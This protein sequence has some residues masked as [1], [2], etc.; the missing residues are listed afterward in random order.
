MRPPVDD[1][2]EPTDG[3]RARRKVLLAAVP[4]ILVFGITDI[5]TIGHFS[6]AVAL[7]RLAW[8]SLIGAIAIRLPSAS[9]FERTML[10]LLL[11][12][13]TPGFFTALVQLT[14]GHSSPLF[15]FILAMPLIVAVV[16]Q[17]QPS[18]TIAA[19]IVMLLG[20]LAVLALADQAVLTGLE[21]F[22]QAFGMALLAV[23]ASVAYRR[24]RMRERSAIAETM[25]MKAALRSRD[26]FLSVV[27][28]E[29]R[30]PITTLLL[31]LD[32]I[33]R[34]S[35][36]SDR[37]AGVHSSLEI[38][39]RQT[40]NLAGLV[41]RL[42]DLSRLDAEQRRLEPERLELAAFLKEVASRFQ[43][44]MERAG[45]ALELDFAGSGD[46][47]WDRIALDQALTNLL[48]NAIKFG[49]GK[50]ISIE[51][52]GDADSVRI[53][54][55]DRGIGIADS[56][57]ARIFGRFERAVDHRHY[58][59]LGLG[60]WI[61]RRIVAAMGGDVTVESAVGRGSAFTI[62]LPRGREH[63]A[64][65]RPEVRPSAPS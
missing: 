14:G 28:H 45:S 21:W 52:T 60:L 23:Y 11:G 42:L 33:S 25:A 1:S 2:F 27:A 51:T 49:G 15:H 13:T 4:V 35:T 3:L 7:V 61:A 65:A 64:V 43:P 16:M 31:R 10:G 12:A 32:L 6:I 19:A 20:G 62:H 57:Q 5:I 24:L 53:T 39:R 40:M 54:V 47:F 30:T 34:P 44:E 38:L 36:T 29:L 63:A 55:R 50:P 41:D 56:D 26:E 46:G 22:I 59:G 17:D 37:E 9:V 8:A 58:G 48:S 18:A